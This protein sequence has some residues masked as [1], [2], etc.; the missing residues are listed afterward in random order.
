MPQAPTTQPYGPRVLLKPGERRA[1]LLAWREVNLVLDV[2]A[3]EGQYASMLRDAGFSGR[4]VSFE[5]VP[6]S[7]G[8]LS[9]LREMRTGKPIVWRSVTATAAHA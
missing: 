4:I 9:A 8:S 1:R 2:G 6:R 7:L 3:N 5:A